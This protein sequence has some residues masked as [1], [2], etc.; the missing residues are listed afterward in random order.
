MG[1]KIFFENFSIFSGPDPPKMAK[2]PLGRPLEAKIA[3]FGPKSRFLAKSRI[4]R[5]LGRARLQSRFK[6]R[7]RLGVG[8][9]RLKS[10]GHGWVC[11]LVA[12]GLHWGSHWAFLWARP[13]TG[14]L[15]Q[16]I[17]IFSRLVRARPK[18]RSRF[19]SRRHVDS[20]NTWFV[21]CRPTHPRGWLAQ[22]GG[23]GGEGGS[24]PAQ[25]FPSDNIGVKLR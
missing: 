25:V 6:S 13:F 17:A 20:I 2:S 1:G 11:S 5:D 22:V 14:Q 21:P 10:V 9:C 19:E 18:S 7:S 4:F 15:F 3:I 12:M 8:W 24:S 23:G 16:K